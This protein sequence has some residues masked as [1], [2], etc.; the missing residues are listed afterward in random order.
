M[1]FQFDCL[2]PL[3]GPDTLTFYAKICFYCKLLGIRWT[4]VGHSCVRSTFVG[5]TLCLR[6]HSLLWTLFIRTASGLICWAFV[7]GVCYRNSR[8]S[9]GV[10]LLAYPI[11]TLSESPPSNVL[12]TETPQTVN[13]YSD[14]QHDQTQTCHERYDNEYIKLTYLNFPE[15]RANVSSISKIVR[16]HN[17]KY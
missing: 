11:N 12:F 10:S 5:R 1:I 9:S 17:I 4:C 15:R 13:M 6:C 16:G 7:G 3:L 2:L 8:R 14:H